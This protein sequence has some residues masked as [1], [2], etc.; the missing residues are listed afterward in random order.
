M[1][2]VQHNDVPVA[3]VDS[4]F[5]EL[6]D[7]APVMIWRARPDKLCDWF[8]APWKAFSGKTNEQLFGYGWAE[9]VH[10]EDLQR[11]VSIYQSAFDAR[12]SFTMPY[13][14]KRHDGEYRWLLDNGAPFYRGG[15]FAGYFGSC[16]D[17][18]EQRDLHDHQQVLLAEL[19]HR[20]N[21]NLQLIISFLALS[22]ARAKGDEAKS[23]LQSAISRIRGVGLVQ[24]QLHRN[25]SGTVDLSE[26]LPDIARAVL[27]TESDGAACLEVTAE[28]IAVP[29]AVASTL[30]LIVNE[31]V[32]NSVKYGRA[33]DGG[34]QLAVK[35]VDARAVQIA[36][37]DSGPGFAQDANA[38]VSG[39]GRGT[40]LVDALAKRCG[41]TLVRT[42]S[43]GATVSLTFELQAA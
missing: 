26:Y 16:I 13:R 37:S 24:D 22:K 20:V 42:N 40:G 8:N 23:L 21:N 10:P 4:E 27:A 38:A 17:I 5:R 2:T 12:K 43:P 28:P 25:H 7:N 29:F 19:N 3:M 36:L 34:L 9:D 41:A 1:T 31:L 39:T 35:R 32:T 11:C 15:E 14:L 6:A 33:V 30:G 18:T